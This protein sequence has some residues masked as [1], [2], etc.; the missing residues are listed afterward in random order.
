MATNN[1]YRKPLFSLEGQ[2]VTATPATI[3]A[4]EIGPRARI[5]G[6]ARSDEAVTLRFLWGFEDGTYEAKETDLSV[7]AA[8]TEGGGVAFSYEVKAPFLKV[9]AVRG[10]SADSTVFRI[11]CFVRAVT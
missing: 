10:A 4:G 6:T 2:A 7:P 9:T 8:A 11:G 3:F 5:H 1:A